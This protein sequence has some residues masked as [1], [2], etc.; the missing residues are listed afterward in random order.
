MRIYNQDF[1]ID[2]LRAM[3]WQYDAAENLQGILQKYQDWREENVTQF[4]RDWYRDVFDLRTA[5]DF[6][7]AVWSIILNVP[8]VGP[9]SEGG[10]EGPAWA[11]GSNRQNYGHGNF[12]SSG[13]PIPLQA[14]QKR[15]LLRLRFYNLVSRGAIPETNR[16]LAELFANEGPAYLEDNLDM[17]INYVFGFELDAPTR[18]LF[19]T[20]DVLPRPAGVKATFERVPVCVPPVYG[21]TP[22]AY[23]ADLVDA[24]DDFNASVS[25]CDAYI[26][27]VDNFQATEGDLSISFSNLVGSLQY[28]LYIDGVMVGAGP[29]SE[30]DVWGAFS[31][32]YTNQGEF[33]LHLFTAL[34]SDVASVDVGFDYYVIQQ[35]QFPDYG[36]LTP[37]V[38]YTN[39][40]GFQEIP[41]ML[42]GCTPFVIDI[43]NGNSGNG[44]NG[45]IP[46]QDSEIR[47]FVFVDGSP[48]VMPSDP[49]FDGSGDFSSANFIPFGLMDPGVPTRIVLMATDSTL[50][51]S[52]D[53]TIEIV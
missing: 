9:E 50:S 38:T 46:L 36:D 5:N 31:G 25:N 17:T 13:A 40:P 52:F 44:E 26:I 35:C 1:S 37:D 45:F 8:L 53:F 42:T 28:R 51:K 2:M 3:L 34:E 21:D 18:F 6:G 29:V 7:L 15:L 33:E 19:E 12:G 23:L 24:S 14:E 4:W 48:A 30:G 43:T 22:T 47:W 20:M 11:F 10:K 39:W 16:F 32:S 27:R 49:Y 41:V